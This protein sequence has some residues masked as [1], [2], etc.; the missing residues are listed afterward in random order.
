M[1]K[2]GV[3][4]D[5]C[6]ACKGIWLDKGE[7]FYFSKSQKF[8]HAKLAEAAQNPK[9]SSRL[10]PKTG[11]ALVELH[12][13]DGKLVIDYC[14]KTHGIWLDQGELERIPAAQKV[15]LS[16][17]ID[18]NTTGYDQPDDTTTATVA[19]LPN[20]SL[21]S[22][23]TLFLLYGL[24]TA[25][26]IIINMFGYLS[27]NATLFIGVAFAALQFLFSPFLMDLQM[28]WFYKITWGKHTDLPDESR[29]YLEDIC[30]KKNMKMP[31]I[32]IIPD[33]SPN[34]FTYGHTPNNARIVITEG[35][36][37][38]L[39][40]KE[41]KA[42]IAHEVGHAV[43]WDMLVMTI[44]YIV[45]L[46]LYYVYR[47][48]I[49]MKTSRNDKTA[50]ARYAIAISAY[51]IY[52]ISQYIVLWFSRVRE[53]YADR[54]SGETTNQPGA[55]ASALVK[56]GYGL[57]GQEK[58]K[59]GKERKGQLESVKAMGIFDPG[60]ARALAVASHNPRSMGGEVEKS[61]LKG[62]MRWDLWN[63]WAMYYELHSTHPLI[64]KRLKALS[65]Q[66]QTMGQE[67][68]IV[69]NEKKPESYWD[70]FLIDYSIRALPTIVLLC[71]IA[72][73]TATKS[74]GIIPFALILYGIA[75]L[76]KVLFSYTTALFP[77]MNIASLLKKVKVSAVRPVACTLKG[78]FIGR[79]VPGL[80]WSEDFV[81]QDESGI[82]FID[83]RQ[84][85]GLWNLLFGLTRAKHYIG[86]EVTVEGWYRRAPI[87][88][89]ELKQ[90]RSSS[91]MKPHA[92][93]TYTAK[94]FFAILLII[95]G[96]VSFFFM[97]I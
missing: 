57:A 17:T 69:F 44:A 53:Y 83:Y 90:M 28:N 36:L 7:I 31:R 92:C 5:Y 81:L 96:I 65:A 26:L 80:I 71:A 82:I 78:T 72:A 8:L 37:H 52:I 13:A 32:G 16:L 9:P 11:D 77:E 45:P 1:A 74:L 22:G 49:R 62:A 4:V 58:K 46:F 61:T 20:L 59:D 14:P 48:L 68:Y 51:I 42:V 85:L 40:P 30:K 12:L 86:K 91:D 55:L 10:N 89:I 43:H 38:L 2:N 33:G 60:S 41:L 21:I 15:S 88:Y 27:L 23:T 93:H 70:E 67:P 84:P 79:G 19:P 75:S 35:M 54:F 3:L 29:L 94:K 95:I 73:G 76:I 34:A 39:E 18:E 56:I 25:V 66:S 87:P 6:A 64:A 50:P 24:L 47:T 97:P 63:P